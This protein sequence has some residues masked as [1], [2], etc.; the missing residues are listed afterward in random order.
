MDR[1]TL[2]IVEDEA[3]NRDRLVEVGED[4]GFSVTVSSTPEQASRL[5]QDSSF[6][7]VMSD[8]H[9]G[10]KGELSMLKQAKAKNPHS[11]VIII[12]DSSSV[13]RAVEAV[14]MG[15]YRY[16][17][18]PYRF[19]ELQ[20]LLSQV[21]DQCLMRVELTELRHMVEG[22]RKSTIIGKSPV[23]QDVKEFIKRVAPLDCTIL[24]E[25]ETGVGKEFFARMIHGNSPRADKGFFAV[26]CGSFTE[27]LLSNELF[28]H[29]KEAFTGAVKQRPGIFETADNGTLLL[30][31]ISEMPLTS[32]V[33]LLRV[34]QE[35]S[36]LRVGGAKEVAVDVRVIAATNRNLQDEVAAGRFRKDLLYRLNVIRVAIPP[37]RE[38]VEDISLF[39]H[40]FIAR[41]SAKYNKSIDAISDEAMNALCGY[42]YPGNV[43]ELINTI[44]R[45]VILADANSIERKHLPKRILAGSR[46]QESTEQGLSTLAEM[47]KQHIKRVL[48]HVQGNQ[49]QAAKILGIDR[50]TLWR[51]LKRQ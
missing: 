38:R 48:D 26:N 6:D 42:D 15:A 28:G 1:F 24:L 29:E 4:V 32:Q 17:T 2:L 5:L 35:G 10:G 41:F 34:L 8:L 46:P 30:D 20:N 27:D 25:G 43:R 51:K 13:E 50:I 16:I 36:F 47:E 19:N 40:F 3:E 12:T 21:R 39:C 31:E 37:L 49:T 11:M 23:V 18:K 33:K 44:E 7:A 14:S 22:S 9:T 45:A